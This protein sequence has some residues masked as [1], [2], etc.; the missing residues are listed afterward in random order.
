[1]NQIRVLNIGFSNIVLSSRI[2]S[3]I[4]AESASGKRLRNEAKTSGKLVDATQGRKTRS[5]LI[6]DSGHLI[7]SALKVESLTKRIEANDNSLKAEEEE[8]N[9]SENES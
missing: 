3:I 5:I 2:V 4:Q 6:T 9:Y 7:L 1:M 8:D